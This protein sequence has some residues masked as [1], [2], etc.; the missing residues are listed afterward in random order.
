V[1]PDAK[2]AAPPTD[3]LNTVGAAFDVVGD[4]LV[5]TTS[6]VHRV[7]DLGFRVQ[8]SGFRI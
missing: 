8:G 5:E 4:M 1:A 6:T 3:K 2:E 7:Q